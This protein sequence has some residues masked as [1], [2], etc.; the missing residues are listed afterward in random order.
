MRKL[1]VA[2]I[3]LILFCNHKETTKSTDQ[4]IS[5]KTNKFI[6]PQ[7]RQVILHG[8]NLVNKN[9]NKNYLGDET[10]EDFIAMKEWGFNCIRMGIIWDGLEPEPG[11]YDDN[12]LQGIDERISW[13]KENGLYVFLDMHQD[14]Y[15]VKYSDGAPEWAT[16]TEDMPHIK[17]GAIWSDAYLASLAVQTALDNFWNNTPAPDG[18]GIQEHYARAWKYVAE[19]YANETSVIGYDLMN[20]PFLGHEAQ[21]IL[22]AMVTKGME[23]LATIDGAQLQSAEE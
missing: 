3:P 1:F 14:L 15:S 2:L 5:I 16:I 17:D 18:I 13:A 21:Q 20:E 6:D 7:G 11:I 22:P 23:I 12:Y 19:R 10:S 8:I 4:F 9:T